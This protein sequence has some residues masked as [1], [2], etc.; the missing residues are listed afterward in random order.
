MEATRPKTL[1][2]AVRERIR[3]RHFSRR[4][5]QAYIHWIRRFI[6]F[7]GRRHPRELGKTEVEA[8]LSHLAV[9]RKVSASTQNQAFAALL[10]L[11]RE[12]LELELPKLETVKRAKRREALP[13]VLSRDEVR[14]VLSHLDGKYELIG[15][16]L[17]GAGLRLSECLCLRVQDI[18]FDRRQLTV[19]GGKGGKDRVTMLPVRSVA[20]LRQHLDRARD[21]HDTA[22]NAGAGRVAMPEAL[23]RKYPSAPMEFRW[24]F[25]FPA[26]RDCADPQSGVRV[27]YHL[28]PKAVQRAIRAAV[29]ASG[30]PHRASAH[31]LRHSFATHLLEG[32]TDIRTIQELLGHSDLNTTMIYTHVVGRHGM[33]TV[34]PLDR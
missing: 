2:T 19:R 21:R 10:F 20:A 5:E 18:D 12:V 17:Y 11:Y 1:L 14:S 27:R 8:F 30:I 31:T 4:T 22:L 13:L 33:A 23:A 15:S 3:F 6:R 7:Y 28:H 34:S 16:L 25:V 26:S 24:Q 32:G 29:V 9:D